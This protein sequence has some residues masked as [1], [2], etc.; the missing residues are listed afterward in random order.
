MAKAVNQPN[1]IPVLL[2]GGSGTRLW[3]TSRESYPKQ[4]VQLVD[5]EH[6]LLQLAALRQKYIPNASGWIVVTGDD[7]RFLV[8]QQLAEIGVSVNSILLEPMAKNTAPA[9][10]LAAFEAC[11][12]YSDPVLLV[13][14]ADHLIQDVN[15]LAAAVEIGLDSQCK[16]VL[17]GVVPTRAETGYGYIEQGEARGNG[18]HHVV[19]FREKPNDAIAASYLESG[20][21]LWNSGMFLLNASTYLERLATFEPEMYAL[22]EAAFQGAEVDLDFKRVAKVPFAQIEGQSIDYA[23]M[24]RLDDAVVVPFHGDWSDVGA[25]DS[26][27]Q[28][29]PSDDAG[30]QS[31]GDVHL[32]D[33]ANTYVRSEQRLVGVL[34]VSDTIVIETRDAVLVA[35]RDRAQDVKQLVSELKHLS[36]PEG[37]VH[38][39]VY[40]PWG[41]YEMLVLGPRFQVKQIVVNPGAS[42]SLQMHHHRAEHWIVVS[43]TAQ[44][45]VDGREQL[46]TEDQSIYIPIGSTHRLTNPGK[47]GLVLIEVQ[48]GSYLG[49]DDIVRFNDVYGRA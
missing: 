2:A 25:W 37:T 23:V 9:V 20:R 30:N 4:F 40:R 21:Y 5:P 48:S 34:G 3:P 16:V 15:A 41:S 35:H 10:A 14:T 26:V 1:L 19:S 46:L 17:F 8:A 38:Q 29:L 44:V 43:G 39:K 31:Q 27:A 33:C 47:V 42:L 24:E 28:A 36:R 22:T 6:S 13:Q 11:A 49:E 12:R 7:Y 45:E 32:I 18:A